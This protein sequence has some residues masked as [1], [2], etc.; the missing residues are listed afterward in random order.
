M[1][2]SDVP[3]RNLKPGL[4]V[5]SIPTGKVGRL[6]YVNDK[7]LDEPLGPEV[8]IEWAADATPY[9]NLAEAER[10]A[11]TGPVSSWWSR[12]LEKVE[13]LDG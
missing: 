3:F 1:L 11:K 8:F 12:L 9:R 4:L 10:K 7:D 5:R 13:V 2:L 6:V